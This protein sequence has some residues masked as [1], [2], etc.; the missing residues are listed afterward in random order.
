MSCAAENFLQHIA[1]FYLFVILYKEVVV[2]E[3][4]SVRKRTDKMRDSKTVEPREYSR[5]KGGTVLYSLKNRKRRIV[6]SRIHL[7]R[8][9]FS[10]VPREKNRFWK[11]SYVSFRDILYE[12][13]RR[14]PWSRDF[15]GLCLQ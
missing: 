6:V 14:R 15:I 8:N 5:K 3:S 4:L 11:F 7:I 12:R 13:L 2:K 10:S 9:K 1:R